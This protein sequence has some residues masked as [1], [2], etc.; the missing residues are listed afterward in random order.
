MS[1]TTIVIG[2]VFGIGAM[3]WLVYQ[4][5]STRHAGGESS[6]RADANAAGALPGS[7]HID[8]F[9]VGNGTTK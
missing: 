2:L 7:E 4:V 5:V 1:E 6:A 3:G 9:T 8:N